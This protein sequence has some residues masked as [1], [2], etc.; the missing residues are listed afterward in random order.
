LYYEVKQAGTSPAWRDVQETQ[1][2]A[3]RLRDTLIM[4]RDRLQGER[5]LVVSARGKPV[6]LQFAL[7][8]VPIEK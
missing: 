4:N 6:T 3:L 1:T 8:A 5:K 7:F 2:L